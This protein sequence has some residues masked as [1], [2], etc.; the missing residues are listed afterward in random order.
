M[1]MLFLILSK[2]LFKCYNCYY[3]RSLLNLRICIQKVLWKIMH[4]VLGMRKDNSFLCHSRQYMRVHLYLFHEPL[5][6]S[7]CKMGPVSP[8]FVQLP[9]ASILQ[10]VQNGSSFLCTIR[11]WRNWY[12]NTVDAWWIEL[13]ERPARI[14]TSVPRRGWWVLF[15]LVI[16]NLW[17]QP[18]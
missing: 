15:N 12:W 11:S 6:S 18:R 7:W 4:L 1:E 2:N 13:N 3:L 5:Y 9:R 17:Y 16:H 10:L 14:I 8:P